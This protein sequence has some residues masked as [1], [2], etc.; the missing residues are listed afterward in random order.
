MKRDVTPCSLVNGYEISEDRA[1]FIYAEDGEEYVPSKR[2]Y[3]PVFTVSNP[4]RQEFSALPSS[5]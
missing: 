1:E 2:L 5:V 3:L 4:R